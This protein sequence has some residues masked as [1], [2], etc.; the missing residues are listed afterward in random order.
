MKQEYCNL[1]A[2]IENGFGSC[3]CSVFSNDQGWSTG[4]LFYLFNIYVMCMCEQ[5]MHVCMCVCML[6]CRGPHV[7]IGRQLMGVSMSS[8]DQTWIIRLGRKYLWQLE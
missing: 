4:H 8:R 7:E 5:C 2:E 3:I 1:K 6:V